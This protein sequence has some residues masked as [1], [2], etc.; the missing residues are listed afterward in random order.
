MGDNR[1]VCGL[2]GYNGMI[3]PPCPGCEERNRQ[4][5]CVECGGRT[6]EFRGTGLNTQY[7]VCPRFREP[8]H[9]SEDEMVNALATAR[10]NLTPSG[11]TA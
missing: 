2:S 9:L 3:D 7:R 1:H 5:P 8:G 6:I 4:L 11:R 10:G